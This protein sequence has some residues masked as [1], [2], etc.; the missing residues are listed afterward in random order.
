MNNFS[1]FS[2]DVNKSIETLKSGGIILCPTDTVWGLSCDAT[3]PKAVEKLFELKKRPQNMSMIVLV[4]T[5]ASIQQYV[6][7]V[8]EIAWELLDVADKPLTIVY[9]GAKNLAQNLISTDGTIAIRVC[10]DDFCN[11]LISKYRKPLVSTSANF[12]GKNTPLIFNEI[13]DELISSVDYVVTYNQ[14]NTT[15]SQPS[16]VIKIGLGGEIEIIRK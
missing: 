11:A 10:K 6:R 9:P 12:S 7:E 16:S 3:N 8:P 13:S 1:D 2:L 15:K 14:E 5:D 4:A